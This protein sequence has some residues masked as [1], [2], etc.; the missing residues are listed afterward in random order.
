TNRMRNYGIAR[1]GAGSIQT[2][3]LL[4]LSDTYLRRSET[5]NFEMSATVPICVRELETASPTLS[6][7]LPGWRWETYTTTDGSSVG[8]IPTVNDAVSAPI[9]SGAIDATT[10]STG[11]YT[12]V[13]ARAPTS[14]ESVE[15]SET[16]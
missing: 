11:A 12:W 5:S 13:P 4:P 16:K 7:T 9:T 3:A 6:G 8:E 15:S 2:S 1:V 14:T 10:P